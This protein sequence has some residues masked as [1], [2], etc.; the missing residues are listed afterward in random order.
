MIRL[1]LVRRIRCGNLEAVIARMPLPA[2]QARYGVFFRRIAEPTNGLD[3][4]LIDY[5][6]L[7]TVAKLARMAHAS[8]GDVGIGFDEP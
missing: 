8:I 5:G 4:G 6:D 1:T 7:L 2:G 3:T